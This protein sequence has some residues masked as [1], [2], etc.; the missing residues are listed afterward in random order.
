MLAPQSPSAERISSFALESPWIPEVV[1]GNTRRLRRASARKRKT[2]VKRPEPAASSKARLWP[3]LAGGGVVVALV[4]LVVFVASDLSNNPNTVPDPPAGVEY[5][6]ISD[7]LHTE[8]SVAY[9]QDPPAG[10]PHSTTPIRC[11]AYDTPVRNEN[12]VHALEHGAAWITYQPDLDDGEVSVLEGFAR[13]R[14]VLVS[15][16]PGQDSPIVLTTWATQLRLD[17]ADEDV[18]DQFIRALQHRTAPE[19]NV[20]C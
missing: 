2:V 10:G 13:R 11:Q 6:A 12:A 5:L 9:E 3:K 17:S 16:Y 8:E 14:D 7:P 20:G 15:P 1:L 4:L 19:N 18:I